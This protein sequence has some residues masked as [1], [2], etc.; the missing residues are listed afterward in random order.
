MPIHI[1]AADD[2][3]NIRNLMKAFLESEGYKVTLF[4]DGDTLLDMFKIAPCDLVILDI[5]MPGTDGLTICHIIRKMSHVPIIMLTAKDTDTDYITGITIGSDDYLSK[6]FRPTMLVMRIKAIFRRIAMERQQLESV[7]SKINKVDLK[8]GD[9]VYLHK[10]HEVQCRGTNLKLTATELRLMIY[11]LNRKNEAISKDDL[12]KSVWGQN[13][14][15]ETRVTDETVRRIRK[16]LKAV[17]STTLIRTL[18]GYG[19]K[20]DVMEV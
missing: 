15:L 11:I 1:Y 13:V 4:E 5:M 19:Y 7:D 18:W 12:L 2:D 20:L 10:L 6:P 14:E 17:N 3:I 16:K 9:L 8:F